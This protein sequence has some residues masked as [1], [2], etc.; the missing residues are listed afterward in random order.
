[1][2]GKWWMER[3]GHQADPSP[4]AVLRG[5]PTADCAFCKPTDNSLHIMKAPLITHT[6]KHIPSFPTELVP[7]TAWNCKDQES[8][9]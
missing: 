2:E 4:P 5:S 1:M 6:D 8:T 3:S 9:I 7:D